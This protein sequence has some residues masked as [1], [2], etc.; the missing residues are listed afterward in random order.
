MLNDKRWN[1]ENQGE[2]IIAKHS[3]SAKN[4]KFTQGFQ[5]I[6][7]ESVNEADSASNTL[8]VRL[9]DVDFGDIIPL[10]ISK[11]TDGRHC[12]RRYLFA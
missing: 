4:M 1:L 9:K 7:I 6:S 2:V 3:A 8:A 5:E 10:V 12:K 11:T